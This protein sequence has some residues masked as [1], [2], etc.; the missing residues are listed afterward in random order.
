MRRLALLLCCLSCAEWRMAPTFPEQAAERPVVHEQALLGLSEPGDAA[1]LE[2]VDAE[3]EEPRLTLSVWGRAGE[4]ART[5]L[6]APRDRARAVA[7]QIRELGSRAVP[8]L[9][10]SAAREWPQAGA[11]AVAHGYPSRAPAQ[12]GAGQIW[13]I[14]G[15]TD[16]GALPFSLRTATTPLPALV[17]LLSDGGSEEIEIARMPL[18]GTL[19][20]P[21]LWLQGSMAWLLSG[22]VLDRKPLRRAIGLRRAS[23]LRGEARL[24]N[25]HGLADHDAGELD[26]AR[27]EFERA[28][29]ADPGFLDGLYNAAATSA[30]A[31]RAEDAVALLA[32]AVAIDPARVQ[33]LGRNDPDLQSVRSRADVRALLGLRRPPPE[34]VPPPP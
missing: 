13:R 3:G 34:G 12:P 11:A 30:L 5:L 19:A 17:L 26:A 21:Q 15:A 29:A 20:E 1:V 27:R 24:H 28:I 31:G 6:V 14:S 2:L 32:R 33:V 10:V 16:A 23:L 4:P 25:L 18:A 7:E 22:S 8:L 9:A